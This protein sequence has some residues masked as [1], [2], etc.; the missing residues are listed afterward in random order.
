MRFVSICGNAL[1]TLKVQQN[2]C[3]RIPPLKMAHSCAIMLGVCIST[4]FKITTRVPASAE[5]DSV[6][7]CKSNAGLLR[8]HLYRVIQKIANSFTCFQWSKQW[9]YNDVRVISVAG[10]IH[11]LC[12][13]VTNNWYTACHFFYYTHVKVLMSVGLLCIILCT[14]QFE[15]LV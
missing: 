10:G 1:C 12:L 9:V 2:Y 5:L 4:W 8:L 7:S 13:S 11:E 14:G 3:C 6:N 15:R